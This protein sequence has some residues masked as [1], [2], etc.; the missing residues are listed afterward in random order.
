MQ[1]VCRFAY[2]GLWH[3]HPTGQKDMMEA[4]KLLVFLCPEKAIALQ[5]KQNIDNLSN[6]M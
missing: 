6:K 5:N 1:S 4:N 2:S 3:V